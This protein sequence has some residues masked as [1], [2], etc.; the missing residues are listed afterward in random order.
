MS[1]TIILRSDKMGEGDDTLGAL[2]MPK[3][4]AQLNAAASKPDNIVFYNS[5]VKLLV[6]GTAASQAL[7]ELFDAGVDLVAC[8]TCITHFSIGDKLA[9]GRVSGMQEIVDIINDSS[10]VITI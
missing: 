8:G 4:L 9:T 5:A 6:E 10:S 7:S 3:F 2:L 1:R